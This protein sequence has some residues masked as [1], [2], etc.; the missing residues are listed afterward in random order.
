MDA[1][2]WISL[3]SPVIDACRSCVRFAPEM[4]S[5]LDWG[6]CA[7]AKSR[8]GSA[9]VTARLMVRVC[10]PQEPCLT[11]IWKLPHGLSFVPLR[12][13]RLRHPPLGL[14]KTKLGSDNQRLTGRFI[15]LQQKPEASCLWFNRISC[16]IE[17]IRKFANG[18]VCWYVSNYPSLAAMAM[19]GNLDRLVWRE[20]QPGL[21]RM[22]R[23]GH[24]FNVF[25]PED[26]PALNGHSN[27]LCAS[28][29]AKSRI[30]KVTQGGRPGL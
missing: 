27:A 5:S 16:R 28:R 26:D 6:K 9:Y 12:I 10:S 21:A 25:Q 3:R 11:K 19:L 7:S 24:G 29:Q 13:K 20:A 8:I 2:I 14:G 23:E 22:A 4:F 30:F 1:A 17:R 18:G 15:E